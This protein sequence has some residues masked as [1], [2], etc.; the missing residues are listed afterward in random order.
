MKRYY[1]VFILSL[2]LAITGCVN[3]AEVSRD[4]AEYALQCAMERDKNNIF[5]DNDSLI[6]IAV[7]YYQ[8]HK[9][10][11][12]T[13]L[14]YYHLGR[15]YYNQ[16]D[17]PN[18]IIAFTKAEERIK[19]ID[20]NFSIGKLY[21]HIGFINR[22]VNNFSKSL[23]AYHKAFEYYS[24]TDSTS[25]Q[26]SA[27][28]NI[29]QVYCEMQQY[30]LAEKYLKDGIEQAYKAGNYILLNSAVELFVQFC[31]LTENV[32]NLKM[33]K[34]SEYHAVSKDSTY[35]DDTI[36]YRDVL[37]EKMQ[38]A[39]ELKNRWSAIA[40]N[41]DSSLVGFRDYHIHTSYNDYL[42]KVG[43]YDTLG[44]RVFDTTMRSTLQQPII[45]AQKEYFRE[46]NEIKALELK[47]NR[48]LLIAATAILLLII[49]IILLV[50]RQIIVSKKQE[51]NRYIDIAQNLEN[52]LFEQKRDMQNMAADMNREISSLFVK[53]FDLF[54]KLCSTYYD[55]VDIKK[56]KEHLFMLIKGEISKLQKDKRSIMQLEEIVNKHKNNIMA[57]TRKSIP[58][59]SEHDYQLLCFLY[60]G[61][62][63][64]AISVFTA[65]TVSSIYN[66][67]SR[68][69]AKLSK[70]DMPNKEIL[71]SNLS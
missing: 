22:V 27:G 58:D 7:D 33:I 3:E 17:Y 19:S 53:Q 69:K 49:I 54:D 38:D 45:D 9:D 26:I 1:I 21:S 13:F 24:K 2:I 55:T 37:T 25:Y 40:I 14:A 63:A 29:G 8:A 34:F 11:Y 39:K 18:A 64:K 61:F 4:N 59:L 5:Y 67:K 68:L 15:I 60:A 44:N 50:S 31:W 62:S 42:S 43:I 16:T 46:Q 65:D 6:S 36:L 47:Y 10:Y 70:S 12:K 30:E 52:S 41:K 71:I 32:E 20:D 48:Q 35:K 66:K 57:V 56:E 51:I 28:I 23:V